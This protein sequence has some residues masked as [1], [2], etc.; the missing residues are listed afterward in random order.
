M[1]PLNSSLPAWSALAAHARKVAALHLR[2]LTASDAKRW[3]DFH[4]EV[5]G[6]LLDYSRQRVTRETMSLLI[7]VARAAGLTE[8]ITAMFRGDKI[9]TTEN[10]AVLH[11]ALRSSFAGDAA[12]QKEVRDSRQKLSAFAAQVRSGAKRGLSGKPFRHVVNIGIGGSDLGPLLVCEALRHE[13]S[14]DITPHFVSNV[15]RTQLEDLM[16]SSIDPSETLVIVC[17]KTFVTQETQANANAAR[18][19]IVGALG[20]KAAANHFVAV[21][22]NAEAM[23][24]FGI[25]ADHRFTM[26]DWVGGRYSVLSEIGLIAEIVIG[27]ERFE[28]FLAGASDIDK[29]FTS[30]PFEQNLPVIT[31][32][33]SVWN[34][35][36]LGLPTLAVLPYDQRLARLPAYLQQLEMESNGKSV[37]LGGTHVD[38]A[39]SPV[40]WGE[41]GSNAQHSFF[42]MLHQGTPTAALDF[43]APLR[44][45]WGGTEG[46]D[47]ALQNCLGQSQAFAF[48]HTQAQVETDMRAAGASAEAITRIAPHR[49]H[50]GNRPSSL[51]LY[52]QTTARSLGSILALY[53]H[54]VLV[55]GTLWGINSFDQFGVELGKKLAGGISIA[56]AKAPVGDGA[57]G[58][59]KLIT[60]INAKRKAS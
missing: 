23:D 22:T 54:S 59:A 37:S 57:E 45:S 26:W 28:E 39:T 34:R 53:E 47:L 38:F 30:A 14:G 19:W 24:K 15:D 33:L 58:F 35:T 7:D 48:G 6:W 41:P 42:Q 21:S 18:A 1:S 46:Q 43:I 27:S 12:I 29:H 55:Q 3:Q 36:F 50:E 10:R 20:E 5:G 51:L 17:S 4:L 25:A 9:N 32:C 11:T 8:R 44:G 40:V 56:G 2:E 49:V 60:Y 31:G 13:W 52:A 16:R